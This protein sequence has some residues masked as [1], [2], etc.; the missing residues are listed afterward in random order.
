[1]VLQNDLEQVMLDSKPRLGLWS[2]HVIYIIFED[3]QLVHGLLQGPFLTILSIVFLTVNPDCLLC[4]FCCNVW[5]TVKC[6]HGL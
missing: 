2:I 1:M 4:V 5:Y 6:L 3:N